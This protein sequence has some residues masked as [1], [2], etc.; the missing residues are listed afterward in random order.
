MS[1][2]SK[3]DLHISGSKDEECQKAIDEA[4]ERLTKVL[5]PKVLELLHGT[6]VIIGE[7]VINSGAQTFAE[8]KK[9]I[10]DSEKN[11]LTLQEA[12]DFLVSVDVLDRGDWVKALPQEKDNK[13]SCLTYQLVHEVGHVID[14]LTKQGNPYHRL[15][16][17]H[18]P[19]KHG[20]ASET[21]AFAEAFTYVV[22]G[23]AI[24]EQ[25]QSVIDST[26]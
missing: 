15:A 6:E 8:E 19:T 5:S 22:F 17:A 16:T 3:L 2:L 10:L 12:E 11:S 7:G 13:W 18:S 23:I 20:K 24:D 4:V 21:E 25:A 9:I 14:G 26:I 1:N